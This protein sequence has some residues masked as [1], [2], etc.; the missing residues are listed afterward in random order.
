LIAGLVL[1]AGAGTRFDGSEPKLL[2]PLNG[3]PLVEHAIT[4]ICAVPEIE[5]IVVV[6][7]SQA[8]EIRDAVDFGR[9]ELTVCPDWRS[10]QSASLRSGLRAITNER[11]DTTRTSFG[12]VEGSARGAS[13]AEALK[14]IVTLGDEPLVS[15]AAIALMAEQPAGARATYDGR[16]GHPVVLGAEQ[17][18]AIGSLNGDHGARELLEGGLLVECSDLGSDLDVDT[19]AD[20]EVIRSEA[21]AG[22]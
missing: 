10:G 11:N 5:R 4:A 14:V 16:P 17:I 22:V 1:A 6:L 13:D 21:R 19:T 9:A 2:A 12:G 15:P 7:G 18:E 8:D 20:L 3:R